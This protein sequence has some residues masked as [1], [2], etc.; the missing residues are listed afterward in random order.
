MPTR[1]RKLKVDARGYPVPKFVEWIDGKPDFRC[2][3]GRWLIR[4]VQ[5]KLCWVCGEQL[6]RYMAFLI[7]PLCAINRI[8]SEPPSHLDCARFA[9]KACPFLTQPRRR[10]NEENLP[11]EGV[12]AAGIV[13]DRNPGVALIWVTDGYGVKKLPDG[14][15]F[16]LGEPTQLEW[17]AHGRE[18]TRDE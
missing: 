7:G 8:N 6:G 9:A 4:C 5:H 1:I 10:R 3:D 11:E 12:P 15:L 18:A 13:L 14:V 17:Y 2:V 16:K